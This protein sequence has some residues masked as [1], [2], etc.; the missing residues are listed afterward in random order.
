MK[1]VASASFVLIQNSF[2]TVL[3]RN[4]RTARRPNPLSILNNEI[5]E[6]LCTRFSAM[7]YHELCMAC[8]KRLSSQLFTLKI[9]S[10]VAC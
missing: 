2:P 9:R 5:Q 10:V 3:N 7:I 6:E 1:R 8:E 4:L